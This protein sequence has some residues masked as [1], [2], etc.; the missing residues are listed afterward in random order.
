MV[1]SKSKVSEQGDRIIIDGIT[2]EQF[3]QLVNLLV[4]WIAQGEVVVRFVMPLGVKLDFDEDNIS[5]NLKEKQLP[6]NCISQ[7]R[8]DIP[9]MLQAILGGHRKAVARFIADS[10]TA[11]EVKSAPKP[12]KEQMREEVDIRIRH[13]EKEVITSD[14]RRQFAIKSSAKTNTY[15]SVSWDI[16]EKRS[17]STSSMPPDIVQATVRLNA[18]KPVATVVERQIFIPFAMP[19]YGAEF[20]NYVLTMTLQDLLDLIKELGNAVKALS[21]AMEVE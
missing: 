14:L 9:F 18:Q 19:G 20:E 13:V 6:S 17:D 11:S 2:P 5:R 3:D 15:F 4:G 7:L 10:S 1:R 16:I 21:Q 8:N 12:T